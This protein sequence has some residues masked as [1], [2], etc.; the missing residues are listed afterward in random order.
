MV[1]EREKGGDWDI[2]IRGRFMEGRRGRKKKKK[3]GLVIHSLLCRRTQEV[4]GKRNEKES[5]ILGQEG[6]KN[7]KR[8]KTGLA[9]ILE[10]GGKKKRRASQDPQRQEAERG[11]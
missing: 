9:S 5:R 2:S 6:R 11:G 8:R 4:G 3:E 10:G 7:G 1:G